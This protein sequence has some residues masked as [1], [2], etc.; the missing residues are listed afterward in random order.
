MGPLLEATSYIYVTIFGITIFHEKMSR[1][2]WIS[3]LLILLGIGLYSFGAAMINFNLPPYVGT[4]MEYVREACA[5][6]RKICGDG[7]LPK[8]VANGSR[9]VLILIRSC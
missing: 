5:V 9:T 8:N 1:R 3:L 4:E 2:K 6:N 7:P